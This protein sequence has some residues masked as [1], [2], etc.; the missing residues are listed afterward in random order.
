MY[1]IRKAKVVLGRLLRELIEKG[2]HFSPS[3]AFWSVLWWIGWCN[4]TRLSKIYWYAHSKKQRFIA[5]FLK[6]RHCLPEGSGNV[7]TETRDWK[8]F[9]FW[10][11]GVD[12]M[13]PLVRA[14]YEKILKSN[15]D[16]VQLITSRNIKQWVTLPEYLYEKLDKGIITYTHFSD[17]LRVALLS[18]HGGLWVDATCWIPSRI[19][20]W[21][22]N[23]PC[24]SPHHN[25]N[26]WVGWCQGTNLTHSSFYDSVLDVFCRY[27]KQEELLIDYLFIDYVMRIIM[28]SQPDELQ[29]WQGI[30][31]N[32]I[33]R[34]WL[35]PLLNQKFDQEK[36]DKLLS[37]NFIFKL[38]YKN[39]YRE[40]TPAGELTFYGKMIRGEL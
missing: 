29:K 16:S 3:F 40:F 17:I 18:Q 39:K 10:L 15:G 1:R 11:Q 22:R 33:G 14:C 12:G 7:A 20:E 34:S 2:I 25:E 38:S 5:L 19:P 21:V 35:F 27:W 36:Y 23:C 4:I 30:P 8:I 32:N 24:F 26:D 9:F 31:I 6:R 13:P 37:E 28:D